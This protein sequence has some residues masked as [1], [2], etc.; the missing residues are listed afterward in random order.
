MNIGSTSKCTSG[1]VQ[2]LILP[3]NA[4]QYFFGRNFCQKSLHSSTSSLLRKVF[5]AWNISVGSGAAFFGTF[6]LVTRIKNPAQTYDD[7]SLIL[8]GLIR[9]IYP[10]VGFAGGTLIG[11]ISGSFFHTPFIY[12]LYEGAKYK[13]E[14]NQ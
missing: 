4:T 12:G 3:S 7:D 13:S 10:L 2:S 1:K 9:I 8:K 11:A 6:E 14:Q 5:L